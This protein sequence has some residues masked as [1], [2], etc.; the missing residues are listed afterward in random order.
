MK[1]NF[2]N[3][4]Y[5]N[6]L[7]F[8]Y[9]GNWVMTANDTEEDENKSKYEEITQKIYSH[10]KDFGCD[11]LIEFNA[12]FGEYFETVEFEE[13]EVN[14]YLEDYNENNFWENLI[15]RLAERDFFKEISP[16]EFNKLSSEEKITRTQTHEKKWEEEFSK[17]GIINLKI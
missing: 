9:L 4:E 10:A 11:E 17:N 7:D 13:S 15:M 8:L 16:G 12:E 5:R 1:I 2:T 3:K 14:Q 6:L